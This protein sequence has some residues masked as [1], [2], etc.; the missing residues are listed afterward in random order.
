MKKHS[1]LV[2]SFILVIGLTLVTGGMVLK[3]GE[4]EE[5]IIKIK[6]FKENANH[7][8][9]GVTLSQTKKVEEEDGVKQESNSG[10]TI[11]SVFEDSA[12]EKAGLQKGDII[13]KING[14]EVGD[15]GEAV[16]MI[17]KYMPGDSV[18]IGILRDG[19][20]N[21]VVAVLGERPEKTEIFI[22]QEMKGD[23]MIWHSSGKPRLGVELTELSDQLRD[24]FRVD[25]DRGILVSRVIEETP[26]EKAGIKAGD[27]IIALNGK[28]VKSACEIKK[29][30]AGV[31]K[32]EVVQVEVMRDGGLIAIPAEIDSEKGKGKCLEL[33]LKGDCKGLKELTKEH[34]I[35]I[36]EEEEE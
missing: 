9:L 20:E 21:E 15:V 14:T 27:V 10:V 12:A 3:A 22:N 25:A 34:L 35:I 19:A 26:A 18:K 5:K 8:W 23:H 32:G 7:G 30:L 13:A 6:R 2:K 17:G 11:L 16:E 4:N 31:E 33:R 24:Y 36:E 29:I 28:H 1:L